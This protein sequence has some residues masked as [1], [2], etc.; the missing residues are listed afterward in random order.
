MTC[1]KFLHSSIITTVHLKCSKNDPFGTG[2][3]LHLGATGSC[4]CP[5]AAMLGYLAYR[6]PTPGPLFIFS[7]GSPLSRSRLISCLRQALGTAGVDDTGFSG[8]SFRIGAATTAAE[9][10]FSD[11][12][13]R[14]L[15][16]WKSSVFTTYIRTPR[17]QLTAASSLLT[18]GHP[19]SLC[20]CYGVSLPVPAAP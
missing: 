20:L 6:P 11:S 18:I 14:L 12:F 16:S 9:A 5:V 15:R 19:I 17:Q 8:H 10:D 2:T 1:S 7:D 4:L 3:M 13:I